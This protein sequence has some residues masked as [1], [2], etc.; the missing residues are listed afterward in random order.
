M[1]INNLDSFEKDLVL[2][3]FLHYMPMGSAEPAEPT[4]ATRFE[5]MRQYPAVYNKLAGSEIVR[6]IHVS[7]GIQA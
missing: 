7:T 6:V 2:R 3:W 5:F 4:K 1:N